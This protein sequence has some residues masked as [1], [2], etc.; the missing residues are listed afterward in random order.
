MFMADD[1]DDYQPVAERIRQLR[2]KYP[3]ALLRPA[4]PAK[5]FTIMC[6]GGREFI[7][8][9]AACYRS[10]SDT[11]PAIAVAAE[12][13][14]GTNSFTRNSEIMNAETSAWGRA[15]MAALAV[16]DN[17]VASLNEVRNRRA[18]SEHPSERTEKAGT[19][20]ALVTA[21]KRRQVTTIRRLAKQ[22]GIT[23]I[24]M[25]AATVLKI[26]VAGMNQTID[27]LTNT[28]AAKVIGALG[29]EI[30]R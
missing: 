29:K 18:P 13:V 5:P 2:K 16:D 9:T 14:V 27:T 8:Y 1:D 20:T 3:D 26:D 12:P 19:V 22:A 15:I 6:V 17:H 24:E 10:P 7:V 30:K 11:L 28:Q 23:D 25:Y 21:N 4:D